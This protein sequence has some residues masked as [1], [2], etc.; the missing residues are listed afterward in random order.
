MG[1]EFN[2]VD[3]EMRCPLCDY[4]MKEYVFNFKCR[5]LDCEYV[6]K[7][8]FPIKEICNVK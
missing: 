1:S 3:I 4:D 5:N 2:K 6:Y 8:K 7:K